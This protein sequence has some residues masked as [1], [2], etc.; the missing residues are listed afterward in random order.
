MDLLQR[1]KADRVAAMKTSNKTEKEYLTVFLGDIE[2]EAKRGTEITDSL[3]V[4]KIKKNIQNCNTNYSISSQDKYLDE[5][6]FFEQYLPKMAS[7]E[8]VLELIESLKDNGIASIGGIMKE[9]KLA[10]GQTLDGKRASQLVKE[11]L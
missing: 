7:D 4:S 8:E 11:N 3:I 1:M 5:A 10:Y 2:S 6:V 9:L